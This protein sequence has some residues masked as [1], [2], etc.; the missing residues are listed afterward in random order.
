MLNGLSPWHNESYIEGV[1]LGRGWEE[2]AMLEVTVRGL[3]DSVRERAVQ[4]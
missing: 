4:E 1:F 2:D 3:E